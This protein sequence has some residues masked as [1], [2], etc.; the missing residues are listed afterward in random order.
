MFKNKS[1]WVF[2]K[3]KTKELL[4]KMYKEHLKLNNKKMNNLGLPWRSSG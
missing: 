3:K 2:E 1:F 4:S